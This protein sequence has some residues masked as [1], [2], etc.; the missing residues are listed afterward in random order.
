MRYDEVQT[1]GKIHNRLV[2]KSRKMCF[3]EVLRIEKKKEKK[4]IREGFMQI[5]ESHENRN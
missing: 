2:E 1:K 5:S 3:T 4:R